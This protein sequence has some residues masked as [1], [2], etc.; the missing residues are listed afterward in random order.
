MKI[1]TYNINQHQTAKQIK[2]C[3]TIN[4]D[5]KAKAI[6]DITKMIDDPNYYELV[7]MDIEC[8]DSLKQFMSGSGLIW[9]FKWN[10]SDLGREFWEDI[11]IHLSSEWNSRSFITTMIIHDTAY[12]V[13]NHE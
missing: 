1:N 8:A 9:L 4:D 6:A 10:R 2:A 12:M 5:A 3:G 13:W 11:N 7:G